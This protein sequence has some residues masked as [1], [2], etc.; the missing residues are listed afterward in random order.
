MDNQERAS[1]AQSGDAR[2]PTASPSRAARSK[3]SRGSPTWVANLIMLVLG[4]I[5]GGVGHWL[6]APTQTT[7]SQGSFFDSVV[8]K[9][10]HFKGNANAPVTIVEFSDFQ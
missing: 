10:R 6:I 7:D 8:A 4:I 3:R 2:A 1:A 9:T 5:I